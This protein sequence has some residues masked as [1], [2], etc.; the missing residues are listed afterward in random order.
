VGG[1]RGQGN[2]PYA[3]NQPQ[4]P[5][6]QQPH[7]ALMIQIPTLSSALGSGPS[8]APAAGMSNRSYLFAEGGSEGGR[9]RGSFSPILH[10]QASPRP[11]G[12]GNLGNMG[13]GMVARNN[14]HSQSP[15][16]YHYQANQSPYMHGVAGR[17]GS[18]GRSGVSG[19]AYGGSPPHLMG[20]ARR[21][22]GGNRGMGGG[23]GGGGMY[24][25]TGSSPMGSPTGSGGD[26][27]YGGGGSPRWMGHGGHGGGGA[28]DVEAKRCSNAIKKLCSAGNVTE[29]FAVLEDMLGRGLVPDL[30]T[31]KTIMRTCVKKLAWRRAVQLLHM[32]G[33][34]LDVV[35]FTMAINTCGKAGEWEQGLRVLREMDSDDA[36]ARGIL[37]NEVSY[38][39]AISA[40][41]K[42]GRWEL[43]LSLLNE[44]KGRG[45]LLNDVCYG[46]A[47]DACGRAG[48]WQEALKLLNEMAQDGVAANEVCYNS[49]IS[50]CG[51][52]GEWEKAVALLRE[53][54]DGGLTPDELNYNSA[55]SACGKAAQ[56]AHAIR[57]LREMAVQGLC[58]DVVSYGAAI[59]ACRKAG[60]YDRGLALLA[61]MRDVGL[62]PNEVCYH[63]AVTACSEA[64]RWNEALFV[65]SEMVKQ[66]LKPDAISYN[67]AVEARAKS[68]KWD[69]LIILLQET[70]RDPDVTLVEAVYNNAIM[71]CSKYG[72]WEL[73]AT[74]LQEMEYLGDGGGARGAT[75]AH[76]SHPG[77]SPTS[78]SYSAVIDACA[79]ALVSTGA[80]A[81]SGLPQWELILSKLDRMREKG[82]LPDSSSYNA[83]VRACVCGSVKHWARAVELLQEMGS[84]GYLVDQSTSQA[85]VYAYNA[86]SCTDQSDLGGALS[87]VSA[88]ERAVALLHSM[89]V[90]GSPFNSNSSELLY[91]PS[92]PTLSSSPGTSS[93]CRPTLLSPPMAS[94]QFSVGPGEEVMPGK[95]KPQREGTLHALAEMARMD[96][97]GNEDDLGASV[98][99]TRSL[100]PPSSMASP[101]SVGLI[102]SPSSSSLPGP[103]LLSPGSPVMALGP[104]SPLLKSDSGGGAHL[105]LKQS[106]EGAGAE[107][108]K[109]DDSSSYSRNHSSV[110]LEGS[111]QFSLQPSLQPLSVGLV[112]ASSS[113]PS[114]AVTTPGNEE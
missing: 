112:E 40:C 34:P 18:L 92:S 102:G 84:R 38:G 23:A 64:G 86:A 77:L 82:L 111:G 58:P 113:S 7:Q 30:K 90:G 20:S 52:A 93:S 4:K 32:E 114:A 48:Q 91:A 94:T 36:K 72:N 42:A 37:P 81:T 87:E 27:Y 71:T 67:A 73:A 83:A 85:V 12:S 19:A 24:S 46:G 2:R 60:K 6:A 65:L 17:S 101:R 75:G 50:A 78:A 51:K 74:V 107:M 109:N 79:K 106:A 1:V 70:S 56:W 29:V 110:D 39:T 8:S 25:P 13:M 49:A 105:V 21:G 15:R 43:A 80:S 22:G 47:I 99:G 88:R 35:I 68:A 28:M 66:G 98:T 14:F 89:T 69:A 33:L 44:V 31:V 103:L 63:S 62:V 57:L 100:L 76:C 5:P 55:I 41:G 104:G 61:E 97:H 9:N 54:R 10:N 95:R 53:M 3:F 16:Q 96:G 45:L 108:K 26:E 59:D 11:P